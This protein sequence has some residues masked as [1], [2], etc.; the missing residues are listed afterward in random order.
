M[1]VVVEEVGSDGGSTTVS[2]VVVLGEMDAVVG[3]MTVTGTVTVA[4]EE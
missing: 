4:V 2:V 1:V 3:T